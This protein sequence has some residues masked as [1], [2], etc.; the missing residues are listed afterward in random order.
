MFFYLLLLLILLLVR[1]LILHYW[2]SFIIFSPTAKVIQFLP[3]D[4]I[5]MFSIDLVF[6]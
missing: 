6:S 4:I 5:M 1:D 2:I 3:C